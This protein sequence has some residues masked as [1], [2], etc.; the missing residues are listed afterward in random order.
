[1][2]RFHFPLERVRRWRDGQAALEELKLEQLREQLAKLWEQRRTIE[3][4]RTHSEQ[5]LFGQP[6]MQAI[7]LQSLDTYRVHARNRIRDIE[8]GARQAEVQVEQQRQ[9]VIQARRDAELLDR[10]KQKALDEWQSASDRE[11]ENLAGELYLG[12]W[13]RKR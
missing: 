6:S 1:M 5:E 8:N 11:Q 9:R 4:E 12:K 2:K 10:L 7:E 13:G 3:A